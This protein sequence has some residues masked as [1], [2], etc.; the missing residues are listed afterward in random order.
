ML[1]SNFNGFSVALLAESTLILYALK[2]GVPDYIVGV[3]SSFLFLG[4]P[5]IFIGNL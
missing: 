2:I 1:F 3:I 5:F 4:M